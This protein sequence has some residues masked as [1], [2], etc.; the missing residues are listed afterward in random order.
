MKNYILPYKVINLLGH[1]Y[2]TEQAAYEIREFM[3]N[4]KLRTIITHD[5]F[6]K[7]ALRA[8]DVQIVI[9]KCNSISNYD[10]TK[11]HKYIR[12]ETDCSWIPY[13]LYVLSHEQN[14]FEQ[15]DYVNTYKEVNTT[16]PLG[17]NL[18]VKT[19]LITNLLSF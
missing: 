13:S 4:R 17:A 1:A 15:I 16:Y 12:R 2:A 10:I 6:L 18:N 14:Q 3:I 11:I 5:F 8:H 9:N 19:Q 7:Q